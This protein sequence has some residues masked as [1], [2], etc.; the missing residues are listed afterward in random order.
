[1]GL[2]VDSTVARTNASNTFSAPQTVSGSLTA[3]SFTGS[4]TGLTNLPASNLTGTL[5]DANLP[6]DVAR[7]G[8]ANSFTNAQSISFNSVNAA[9]TVRNVVATGVLAAGS[10]YGVYGSGPWG[11]YGS[12]STGNG[13]GVQGVGAGSGVAG[14]SYNGVGVY[15]VAL[16]AGIAGVFN[17]T[18]G[19]RILSGQNNGT[20]VFSIANN[21]NVKTS[22][23][24]VTTGSLTIGTGTAITEHLSMTFSLGVPSLKPNTCTTSTFTFTGASDGDTTALG[25]PNA[26]MAAGNI[27]YSAW[28]SSANTVTIRACDINPNG[29]ATTAVSGTVRVDIWKH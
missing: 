29:P 2:S 10:D 16:S 11:L 7:L 3:T 6:T 8:A 23:S 18:N 21:G 5:S 19:G 17:A 25:V 13:V 24:V 9:L 14:Q 1:V 12:S 22:G 20:E 4:G 26:L 28:V 27:I 15:G